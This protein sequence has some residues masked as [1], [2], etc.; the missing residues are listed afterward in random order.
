MLLCKVEEGCYARQDSKI[1]LLWPCLESIRLQI[2]DRS[3]D[4]P[5]LFL[6]FLIH[7]LL[8]K[9]L[10][11]CWNI[12]HAD[13]PCL[14]PDNIEL[15]NVSS[16]NDRLTARLK[17]LS[18]K[19]VQHL[20]YGGTCSKSLTSWGGYDKVDEADRKDERKVRSCAI[21]Q[22]PRLGVI[23]HDREEGLPSDGDTKSWT[24]EFYIRWVDWPRN[25]VVGSSYCHPHYRQC[26]HAANFSVF[27]AKSKLFWSIVLSRHKASLRVT[28]RVFVCL[29]IRLSNNL[30]LIIAMSQWWNGSQINKLATGRISSR[31]RDCCSNIWFWLSLPEYSHLCLFEPH[32]DS[33][34]H[35]TTVLDQKNP[36]RMPW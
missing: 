16:E 25:F 1:A 12:R 14:L 26:S 15:G 2:E 7:R 28:L 34:S 30:P 20:F 17:T 33:I 24:A 18:G 31:L 19:R 6:L 5:G 36:W 11:I 29:C 4:T 13:Q 3:S 35:R 9:W 27:I 21:L 10:V 32:S 22:L 8:A 23:R